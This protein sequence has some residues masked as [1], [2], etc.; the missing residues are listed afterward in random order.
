MAG[1]GNPTSLANLKHF[2]PGNKVHEKGSRRSNDTE[3]AI[4]A[5]RKLTPEAAAYAGRIL[6]DET[7]STGYRLKAMEAILKYGMPRK[8]EEI[9]AK[10][11]GEGTR[12]FMR[13]EFVRPGD[14]AV[15]LDAK[16]NGHG[17]TFEVTF[18]N[19]K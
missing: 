15:D 10:T 16:P 17:G 6:R 5:F 12:A 7:E 11:L 3:K 19:G 4:T 8:L 13:V 1:N 18:G 2:E 14:D 9:L